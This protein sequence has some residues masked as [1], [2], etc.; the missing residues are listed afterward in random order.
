MSKSRIGEYKKFEPESYST[1]RSEQPLLQWAQSIVEENVGDKI[2]KQRR[3]D[4]WHKEQSLRAGTYSGL[5]ER[6]PGPNSGIEIIRS[7]SLELQ[8]V[9]GEASYE[10]NM[11]I[12][13]KSYLKLYKLSQ[14]NTTLRFLRFI[15]KYKE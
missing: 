13:I 14:K 7:L 5:Y 3:R 12:S 2:L 15:Q 4:E 6:N 1:Y 10:Y 11:L 8:Q 9:W